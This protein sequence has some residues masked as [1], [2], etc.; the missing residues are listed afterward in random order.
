MSVPHQWFC[1]P[2]PFWV[3]SFGCTGHWST[4]SNSPRWGSKL[5]RLGQQASVLVT[6]PSWLSWTDHHIS[7]VR[8]KHDKD[9]GYSNCEL[10]GHM[11]CGP[12]GHMNCGPLGY[13]N[14]GPLGYRYCGPL[15]YRYCV[16]TS[17]IRFCLPHLTNF[18]AWVSQLVGTHGLRPLKPSLD[19]TLHIQDQHLTYKCKSH[20]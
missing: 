15:G 20:T 6:A 19:Q 3:P 4:C 12:L 7:S 8:W 16:I 10:L 9:L 5:S 13:G 14:C 1:L 17:N 2:C 11:Y 18:F